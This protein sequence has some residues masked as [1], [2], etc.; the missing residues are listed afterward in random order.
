MPNSKETCRKFVQQL[1]AAAVLPIV[2]P[3]SAIANERSLYSLRADWLH[4][5]R[6]Y[7]PHT[8]W[9][10]PASAVTREGIT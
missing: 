1:S 4:P 5:T 9:W 10:W 8:R 6:S 7:R 3:A 2:A